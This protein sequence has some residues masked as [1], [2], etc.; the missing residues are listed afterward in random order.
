MSICSNASMSVTSG[1]DTV[2]ANGIQVHGDEVNSADTVLFH[3]RH[4]RRLLS[5]GEDAAV[6]AGME[7]LD[8]A[9]E[10]L[11]K[12]GQVLDVLGIDTRRRSGNG[13][14][15]LSRRPPSQGQSVRARGRPRRPCWTG[16]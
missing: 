4:V 12:A 6:D 16:R 10:Y 8:A 7:G 14:C 2:S 3:L 11:G 15:R 1:F 5:L 13:A 9:I